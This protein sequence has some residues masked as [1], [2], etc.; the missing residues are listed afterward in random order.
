MFPFL[1]AA[2]V[3]PIDQR[4]DALLSQM[5][6]QEK[7]GQ[8]SQTG[9]QD[10]PDAKYLSDMRAGRYGSAFGGGSA[11]SRA[12]I[13]DASRHSRLHIPL[14]LGHDVI[15]GY[16]TGFPIPLA[17]AA[18]WDPE[19]VRQSAAIAAREAA[20]DGLHWTFSPMMD[21][22]RDPR[23]GRIAEGYGEDPFLASQM[24]VA[25]VKGYQ[26]NNRRP[27]LNRCLRKAL[28]RIRRCRRWARLQLDVDT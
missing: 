3:T 24:A 27:K 16:S 14:I 6:L 7:L 5:T 13:E 4:V 26:G 12:V 1:F 2:F 20:Q 22:A 17:Q 23:W 18:T 28:C 19:L 8:M 15:H 9:L 11:A 10:H 21:I 25:T